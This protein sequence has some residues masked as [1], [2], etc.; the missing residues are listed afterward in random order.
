MLLYIKQESFLD[1]IRKGCGGIMR[2]QISLTIFLCQILTSSSCTHYLG[3]Y[4]EDCPE[5]ITVISQAPSGI[6][7]SINQE[8]S[9]K[10]PEIVL[11]VKQILQVKKKA[12]TSEKFKVKKYLKPIKGEESS[13]TCCLP[14]V[15]PLNLM[16]F[17]VPALLGKGF[18][19]RIT[20]SANKPKAWYFRNLYM[21][22]SFSSSMIIPGF[23]YYGMTQNPNIEYEKIRVNLESPQTRFFE[24]TE[25]NILIN[26]PVTFNLD[27][28]G[29][30]TISSDEEGICRLDLEPFLE[31]ISKDSTLKVVIRVNKDGMAKEHTLV[32]NVRDLVEDPELVKKGEE[33]KRK[34]EE[35]SIKVI[36]SEFEE[37]LRYES[38]IKVNE[39]Q[40]DGLFEVKSNHSLWRAWKDRKTRIT[41][42]QLYI[43]LSYDYGSW[44]HYD[45]AKLVGGDAVDVTKINTDVSCHGGFITSC[46]YYESV[47]VNFPVDVLKK[48]IRQ[49]KDLKFQLQ[50][51]VT[52]TGI[53]YVYDYRLIQKLLKTTG[54][55]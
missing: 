18:D 21:L 31:S 14:L 30:K 48:Y 17:A 51:G 8:P 15:G 5:N 39:S 3:Y 22:I 28:L 25:E 23:S 11:S 20:W 13:E 2:K 33:E 54:D 6:D 12:V 55:L 34:L 4:Y 44:I 27:S 45:T 7:F 41:R 40:R 36:D 26:T 38:S 9:Y 24:D 35:F 47:G 52:G 43:F 1:K 19:N 53:I 37:H 32:Y 46:T 42:Y 10:N 49:K 29:E 16:V 50:G